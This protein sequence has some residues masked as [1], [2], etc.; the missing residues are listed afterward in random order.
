MSAND[1]LDRALELIAK[2]H[3][4]LRIARAYMY[5]PKHLERLAA[6][7]AERVADAIRAAEAAELESKA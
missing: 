6:Y 3:G 5:S 2:L 7:D 4:A 1:K